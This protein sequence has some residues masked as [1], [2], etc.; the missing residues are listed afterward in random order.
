MTAAGAAGANPAC[1]VLLNQLSLVELYLY[2]KVLGISGRAAM[3]RAELKANI[4]KAGRTPEY[5]GKVTAADD[6]IRRLHGFASKQEWDD[7]VALAKQKTRDVA[8][9]GEAEVV[10][11][12]E[13]AGK[14]KVDSKFRA[15]GEPYRGSVDDQRRGALELWEEWGGEERGYVVDPY[16]GK[17]LHWTT[18]PKVNPNGFEKFQTDKILTGVQG[19]GY[20]LDNLIPSS[21]VANQSRG[22]T[23]HSFGEPK[24]GDP[25]KYAA[26]IAKDHGLP[27]TSRGRRSRVGRVA[28]GGALSLRAWPPPRKTRWSS[29]PATWT[30]HRA[31]GSPPKFSGGTDG[32][33]TTSPATRPNPSNGATSPPTST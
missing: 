33:G 29:R 23:G 14:A 3:G 30:R 27:Y 32:T 5:T 26:K 25:D 18:D 12:V 11:G 17:K 1:P 8:Q 20:H 6:Q 31:I 2:A 4:A 22:V 7:A 24:W 21:P 10:A 13:A 9:P 19:G 15:G 28:S 16:T